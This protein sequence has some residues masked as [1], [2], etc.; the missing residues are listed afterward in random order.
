GPA[1]GGGPVQARG[2]QADGGAAGHGRY[3]A[4]LG[5]GHPLHQQEAPGRPAQEDGARAAGHRGQELRP[6]HPAAR[7]DLGRHRG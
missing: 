4:G 7:E 2:P 3:R 5:T 6:H 1:P